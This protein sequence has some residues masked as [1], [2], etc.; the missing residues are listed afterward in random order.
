MEHRRRSVIGPLM[1][2]TIGVLFL[3]ANLGYLPFTFWEVAARFWPLILILVGLEIIIGRRSLIGGVIIVALWATL[4]GGL[5]WLATTPGSTI[6]NLAP[7]VTETLNQPLGDLKSA[8]VDLNVGIATVNVT[9]LNADTGD[10]MNGTL[11]H[12]QGMRVVKTYTVVGDEGRLALREEGSDNWMFNFRT[13]RWDLGL[14]PTL[15]LTLRV[16][17]GVGRTNLDLSALN[18]PSLNIDPG[19]GALNITTPKSGATMM[20][21]N[22]GVG[23]VVITIPP[24]VSARIH[25]NGGLGGTR[26]DAARFP[27]FGDTYQSA[28]FAS[29]ANKLDLV[30]DGGVGASEIR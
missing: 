26:V 22:G 5:L 15:P 18:V 4:I 23:N 28:D 19:V 6:L 27:K 20:R 3:L 10:L 17:G 2:I 13:S 16:N 11:A 1:L 25:V 9:A 30:V 14:N 7:A 12:A 21:V 29:A 24:E 8:A